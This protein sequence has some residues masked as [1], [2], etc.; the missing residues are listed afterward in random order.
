MESPSG[1]KV[2][3]SD[4]DSSANNTFLG[5]INIDFIKKEG[6]YRTVCAHALPNFVNLFEFGV[7]DCKY[8]LRNSEWKVNNLLASVKRKNNKTLW[9]KKI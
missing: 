2:L 6:V 3:G 9:N 1:V 4:L 5:M 7:H 8:R